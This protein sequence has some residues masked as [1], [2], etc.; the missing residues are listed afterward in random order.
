MA[1]IQTKRNV[2]LPN[3]RLLGSPQQST[4]PKVAPTGL[5]NCNT[6]LSGK[7]QDS[8]YM[9][10]DYIQLPS[11]IMPPVSGYTTSGELTASE[12]SVGNVYP[13]PGS[14]LDSTTYWSASNL[15]CWVQYYSPH[16]SF[17]AKKYRFVSEN[18][19][20]PR[21]WHFQGSNDGV[22]W[23][24]LHENLVTLTWDTGKVLY[25]ADIP[26]ENQGYY[27][28]HRLLIDE[29]DASSVRIYSLQVYSADVSSDSAIKVFASAEYPL[30]LSFLDG[31]NQDGT[32]NTIIKTLTTPV[33]L[34]VEESLFVDTTFL[35]ALTPKVIGFILYAIYDSQSDTVHFR[36]DSF[37]DVYYT[38]P[39]LA[40]IVTVETCTGNISTAYNPFDYNDSTYFDI[41]KNNQYVIYD[42][43]T[44][45]YMNY[46][47]YRYY[48]AVRDYPPRVYV[49]ED[50]GSTWVQI[51]DTPKVTGT[52]T[53]EEYTPAVY[54]VTKIKI[55][56]VDSAN[57]VYDLRLG[58]KYANHSKIENGKI[59][60]YDLV[61]DVWN[62]VYKIPIGYITYKLDNAETSYEPYSFAY[63]QRPSHILMPFGV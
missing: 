46:F 9:A 26:V 21:V 56:P 5:W 12:G 50:Y 18:G 45:F 4:M 40:D 33:E 55:S 35:Y 15:G 16:R 43:A 10:P 19:Y 60:E 38:A 39:N 31:F 41:T 25:E 59:Y 62:Q 11:L 17:K 58:L 63:A 6:V 54:F 61:G 24:T 32:P 49:S 22:N 42:V 51:Y 52:Y 44:P 36:C 2:V 29:F 23:T 28:Y 47:R 20:T 3:I 53:V 34:P 7:Y 57:N 8:I 1:V 37:N 30:Q 14:Q 13:I 48:N 27:T